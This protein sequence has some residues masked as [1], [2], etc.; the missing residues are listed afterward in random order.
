ME[1]LCTATLF[2]MEYVKQ[3]MF[4][5]GMIENWVVI[6]NFNKLSIT[7]LP[8]KEMQ[9]MIGMLQNNYMYVM[10]KTWCL[11]VTTFQMACWKVIEIFI[12]PETKTKI[13]LHK[14]L[15]PDSLVNNFHPSQLEK[16]FGGT[17]E[18]PKRFWPPI[19]PSQT[20]EYFEEE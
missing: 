4:L 20:F 18:K 12:D 2:T 7:D 10:A 13:S 11:N 5:P 1:V 8:R 6:N 16:R 3:N 17:A 14:T 15:T 9:S 19:S